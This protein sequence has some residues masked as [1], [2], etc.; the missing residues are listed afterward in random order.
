MRLK[1][2]S[3]LAVLLA[4]ASMI[5]LTALAACG[6]TET[7]VQTVVVKEEVSG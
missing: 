3:P 1:R 5:A 4:A 7:V 2:L 6:G